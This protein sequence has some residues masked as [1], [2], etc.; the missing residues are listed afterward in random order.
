[1]GEVVTDRE[2][3][4][5]LAGLKRLDV[6]VDGDELDA[7]EACVDHAADGV[8][9]ATARPDDLDHS[10]IGRLDHVSRS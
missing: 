7:L 3:D 2:L 4:V 9:T 5:G 1:M 10:E 6:R 8:R